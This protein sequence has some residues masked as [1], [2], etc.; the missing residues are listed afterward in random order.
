MKE[1]KIQRTYE[2]LQSEIEKDKKEIELQKQKTI[3]EIKTL[4]RTKMFPPKEKISIFKKIM[5]ALGY[6]DDKKR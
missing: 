2:W 1:T 4:D 3:N 6:G 5:K